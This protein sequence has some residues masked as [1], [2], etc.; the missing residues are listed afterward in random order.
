MQFWVGSI[1]ESL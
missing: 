1:V